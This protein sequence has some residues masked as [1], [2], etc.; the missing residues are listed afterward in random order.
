MN[1]LLFILMFVIKEVIEYIAV[2]KNQLQLT[3]V[4]WL[5]ILSCLMLLHII[6]RGNLSGWSTLFKLLISV[7]LVSDI[8]LIFTNRNISIRGGNQK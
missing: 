3:F 6:W 7:G 5:L 1:E 2:K 4:R 8:Y